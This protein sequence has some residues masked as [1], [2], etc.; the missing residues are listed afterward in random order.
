M[1]KVVPGGVEQ[2][3]G[4]TSQRHQRRVGPCREEEKE[5]AVWAWL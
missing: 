5:E 2:S 1:E 3:V 4:P